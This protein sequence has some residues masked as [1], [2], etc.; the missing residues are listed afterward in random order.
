MKIIGVVRYTVLL[1]SN[2]FVIYHNQ[3]GCDQNESTKIDYQLGQLWV[4]NVFYI[5]ENISTNPSMNK[6]KK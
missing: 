4:L 6:S 1:V 5:D 3:K 2:E